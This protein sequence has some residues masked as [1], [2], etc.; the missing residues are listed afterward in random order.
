MGFLFGFLFVCF[1]GGR[2]DGEGWCDCERKGLVLF[3]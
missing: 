2:G 3:I 1:L